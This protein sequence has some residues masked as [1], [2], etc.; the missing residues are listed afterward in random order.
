MNS[1]K[2]TKQIFE[3]GGVVFVNGKLRKKF[4]ISGFSRSDVES[5]Y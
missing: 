2:I 4:K 3:N 5:N 1:F